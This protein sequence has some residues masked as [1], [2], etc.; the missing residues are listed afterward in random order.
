M[1]S[2]YSLGAVIPIYNVE[3]YLKQC[4]ESIVNQTI[5]FD[6]VIL[7]NDGSLDNSK[8]ICEKYC[9]KYS[10]FRLINQKNQGLGFTRN[11]GMDFSKSDYIIFIDSDD[12]INLKAVEIIKKKLC[13]QDVLFYSSDICEDIDGMEHV[14]FYLRK[15]TLC[16]YVMSGLDFFYQSYPKNHI[17][18][19][20]MAVYK[21][22]FLKNYNIRFPKGIYYEDNFFYIE[23]IINAKKIECISEQLYIRRYRSGSI[24]TN[25]IVKKNCLDKIRVTI[26]V[27]DYIKKNYLIEWNKEILCDYLLNSIL[28]VI[29]IIEQYKERKEIKEQEV[30]FI[31]KFVEQWGDLCENNLKLLHSY[32]SLLKIYQEIMEDNQNYLVKYEVI[33]INLE[34]K[35]KQLLKNLCF[36]DKNAK[37]GIYGMGK[38]TNVMFHLY[39]KYFGR[40]QC[41]FFYVVSDEA[42]MRTS[43]NNKS[44]SIV[45][46]NK[47]PKD[48]DRIII[49]SLTYMN[50][51]IENLKS[52]N[53]EHKKIYPL[54]SSNERFDLVGFEEFIR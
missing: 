18:S 51:M 14:N 9:E 26:L 22:S 28:E 42:Q 1:K 54:Y 40:I 41:N 31:E 53:I 33:K 8:K 38:H 27:W 48:T 25:T 45:L 37:I 39:E 43:I 34:K 21:R 7:I 20:C 50:E 3:K 6:E 16:N 19:A 24:M 29:R 46:Y 52:V 12:F 5:S 32:Y 17:V 44:C 23:I 13:E 11:Q 36:N 2:E 47:I 35:I 30:I 49:S 15:K 4:L 10:Y